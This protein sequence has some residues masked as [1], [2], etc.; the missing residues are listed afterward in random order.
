G[1][2][3][4][5]RRIV[6]VALVLRHRPVASPALYR[7]RLA[8][9]GTPGADVQ[10]TA[11]NPDAVRHPVDRRAPVRLLPVCTASGVLQPGRVAPPRP[12][13]AIRRPRGPTRRGP[14]AEPVR[15]PS[16]ARAPRTG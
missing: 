5:V 1:V 10:R 4:C 6:P 16:L 3:R 7:G 15:D 2:D 13:R 12:G 8:S 14:G 11:E 9:R